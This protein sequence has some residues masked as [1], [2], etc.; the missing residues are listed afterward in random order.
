MKSSITEFILEDKDCVIG[1]R[2]LPED[3]VDLVVTS[4]PYNLGIKYK[5]YKDTRTREDYLDWSKV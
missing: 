5:N 1:M 3:S 2:A 4:P